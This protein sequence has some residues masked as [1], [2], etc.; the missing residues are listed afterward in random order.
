MA[1]TCRSEDNGLTWSKPVL[2]GDTGIANGNPPVLILM[3]DGRLACVYGNRTRKEMLCN[4]SDDEGRSWNYP[5]VIHDN[6]ESDLDDQDFG[7]PRLVQRTDGML[8]AIYY[9]ASPEIH[10]QHIAAT[11]WDPSYIL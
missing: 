8:V 5:I 9:W 1:I 6:Y 2:V 3:T 7:Y 11:V 10:R 4:Y